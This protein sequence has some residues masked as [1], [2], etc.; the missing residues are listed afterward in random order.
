MVIS[1]IAAVAR[2][3]VIGKDNK[4]P[5]NLP[6]DLKYFR[7]KTKGHPV[8]MGK[9]TF[10]SVGRPLPGRTNIILTHEKDF[11]ALGCLLA[12]SLTEAFELAETAPGGEEVF[13]IGG[14]EIYRQTL[15]LAQ[16]LYLTL[17]DADFDGDTFFPEF[18][19][20]AW[21]EIEAREGKVDSENKIPHRFTVLVKK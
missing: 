11:S 16:K 15:P 3:G 1:L 13:V 9:K 10:L 20:S 2:N 14:A 6:D 8:I 4:L 18:D 19:R 12:A 21:Q 17:V 5:W 7:E